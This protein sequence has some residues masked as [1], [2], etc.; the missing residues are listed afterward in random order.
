MVIVEHDFLEDEKFLALYPKNELE[1]LKALFNFV[2][3][4]D[5]GVISDNELMT[6]M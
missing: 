5:S 3:V 1:D 2:D 6:L 4:D